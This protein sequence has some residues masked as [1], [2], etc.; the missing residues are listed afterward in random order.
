M[1]QLPRYHCWLWKKNKI[2]LLWKKKNRYFLFPSIILSIC[3]VF[4]AQYFSTQLESIEQFRKLGRELKVKYTFKKYLHVSSI[5]VGMDIRSCLVQA[6]YLFLFTITWGNIFLLLM[7]LL[8]RSRK[9]PLYR[10]Y[11]IIKGV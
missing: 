11:I 10:V 6:N 7:F 3:I 5:L 2:L 1:P 4:L 8:N 9:Y